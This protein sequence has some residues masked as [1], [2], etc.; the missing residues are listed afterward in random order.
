MGLALI[1]LLLYLGAAVCFALATVAA[2]RGAAGPV[3]RVYL[4]PLG[5]LSWVLVPLIQTFVSLVR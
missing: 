1:Y 5:L 2:R 4:V 3:T